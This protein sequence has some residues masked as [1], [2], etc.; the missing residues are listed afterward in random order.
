MLLFW[1][2][3]FQNR[4]EYSLLFIAITAFIYCL[5]PL[6]NLVGDT[7]VMSSGMDILFDY[8]RIFT[9]NG[10]IISVSVTSIKIINGYVPKLLWVFAGLFFL[11]FQ[12]FFFADLKNPSIA[13]VPFIIIST[14]VCSYYI[15]SGRKNISGAKW[16]VVVGLGGTL[17]LMTLTVLY[18][19]ITLTLGY[20]LSESFLSL[21][22][23]LIVLSYPLSLLVYVYL[24]FIQINKD[25]KTQAD[26][27]VKVSEE[28]KEILA[29]QNIVLEEKVRIRTN[30]LNQSLES[31]KSTQSQ[32]IHSEKMASLG[33]LTAGIAHEIQNPL[34]FVNNFSEVNKE[35]VEDLKQ[36][37]AQN[38][39]EEVDALLEDILANEDKVVHHGKRAEQIVKSML[40][41]SRGTDG[42]KEP[43]DINA[44]CDEYM[45]LAYHGFR[46]KDKSFNADF[47]LDL[48]E[49]LPELKVVPQD[50]G[51]VLLNLIN[52]AF[53]ACT[54][55]SE[56]AS[57]D[58]SVIAVPP[59]VIVSTKSIGD[60]IEI[61]VKDNGPGIPG[62][63][64]DKIFQP[65]FT[66]K[67]TGQ[68]TGLGLSMSYDIVTKGHGGTLEV[69]SKVGKGTEFVIL[70][71]IV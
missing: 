47:E 66:T 63:I 44:L 6:F 4:K 46:A 21:I 61:S 31:L 36:A 70:L 38:D 50:I 3:Y 11:Y 53:Q 2:F 24:W 49:S 35:L 39:Q 57:A 55:R 5:F 12:V 40:Q 59:K 33:E 30:E 69:E 29:K 52:N 10:V 62:N 15:Y 34:N 42:G 27:I 37:I 17:G 20:Q 54:E 56:D 9:L 22:S 14:V 43:I 8:F 1:L 25:I 28:K 67:P 48:D 68:G 71:P 65:F 64:R 32:L 51:R 7:V 19:T 60:S 13:L 16:A 26:Q 18:I 45:R 58:R 41:H 23:A